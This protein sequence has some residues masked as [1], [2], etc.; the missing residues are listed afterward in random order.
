MGYSVRADSDNIFGSDN[1]N[2]WADLNNREIKKEIEN[3]L[4]W[5]IAEAKTQIDSRLLGCAYTVPFEL[6]N[7]VYDPVIVTLSAR[8]V[9][10]ILYDS[11]HLVD[12]DRFDEV[13]YHR[14]IVDRQ[15]VEIH[16]GRIKLLAYSPTAVSYPQA[17][18]STA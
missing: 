16:A 15:Y 7:S 14:Q 3:R 8:L 13:Q 6:V 5:A 12:I 2:K 18:D 11:R 9:G 10:V 17:V 4:T 1:I